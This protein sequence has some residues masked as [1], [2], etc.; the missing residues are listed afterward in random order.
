M[1]NK[2]K[3]ITFYPNGEYYFHKGLKAYEQKD[4]KRSKKYLQRAVRFEPY[5]PDY[6]C[7]LAAVLAELEDYE[8]SN[9]LLEKVVSEIDADITECYFFKANNYVHLGRFDEA[10]K[11]VLNYMTRDADGE[12]MN[13]AR[14]LLELIEEEA[15][16]P[17]P[18][19]E[20]AR[21][22]LQKGEYRKAVEYLSG[23]IG[24]NPRYWEAYN[25]L[26]LGHFYLQN[27]R[28]AIEIL[29]YVLKQQPGNVHALCNL[30]VFY[31]QLDEE[32]KCAE[33]VAKLKRIYPLSGEEQVRLGST[34]MLLGEYDAAFR[35]LKT[36]EKNGAAHEGPFRYWL[37]VSSYFSGR[38]KQAEKY[39]PSLSDWPQHDRS[40]LQF[41]AVRE[42]FA[43]ETAGE[44]TLLRRLLHELLHKGRRMEER[45]FALFALA[46]FGDE[47][48]IRQFC[49][50]RRET[51]TALLA[52]IAAELIGEGN[53]FLQS[54]LDILRQVEKECNHG[55]PIV[56]QFPLYWHWLQYCFLQPGEKRF[57][58][59]RIWVAV[60]HYL[61][62]KKRDAR[63][64]QKSVANRYGVSAATLGRYARKLGMWRD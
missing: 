15:P 39:W 42:M 11:E 38:L 48:A 57:A 56:D 7:Q 2:R 55:Q 1:K 23:V 13:E 62:E 44:N 31:Q 21:R 61:L 17:E 28:H 37:A 54:P 8:A 36:A 29:E 30:A 25:G 18:E 12:F 64:T 46:R 26:A 63:T 5:E 50:G 41:G 43:E 3:V 49:D 45:C 60:L 53:G 59:P 47:E 35:W 16:A 52:E 4:L 51:E 9:A 33:A 40:P 14:E 19:H 24:E 34:F 6:L 20:R 22:M 27:Y 32:K 58:E 10:R